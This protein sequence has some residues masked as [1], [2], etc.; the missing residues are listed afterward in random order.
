MVYVIWGSDKGKRDSNE[1]AHSIVVNQ[2]KHV[3][4]IKCANL[5]AIY[6]GHGGKSISK[7]LSRIIPSMILNKKMKYPLQKEDMTKM[8]QYIQDYLKTK[9]KI[10]S[11]RC[12]STCLCAVHYRMS[13]IFY[14]DVLNVGDSRLVLCRDN[15][16]IP[17][18]KDHKPSWPEEQQRIAKEGG[19]IQYDGID[20]R[21]GELSVSRAF[22]DITASHVNPIPDVFHYELTPKDQFIVMG[23]DGLW[24]VLS[25]QDVVNFILHDCNDVKKINKIQGKKLNT[26]EKLIRHAIKHGSTDNISVIILFL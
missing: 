6:D 10:M 4:D 18:T 8:C 20:W 26:A 21:V 3:S 24:D 5:I 2:D 25:C 14:L 11:A 19:I 13:G 9:H 22:G 17:L 15:M 23:C 1:D 12:G 7:L 16:A